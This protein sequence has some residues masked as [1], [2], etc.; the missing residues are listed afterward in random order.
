M[1]IEEIKKRFESWDEW[2]TSKQKK[3]IHFRS[4]RNFVVHYNSLPEGRIKS[5]V[6]L[7]LNDYIEE[8]MEN[9][10]AFKGI[11]S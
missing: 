8:S 5:D 7:L 2:L 6:A 9:Q 3:Y 11:N 10:C 4:M 1:E